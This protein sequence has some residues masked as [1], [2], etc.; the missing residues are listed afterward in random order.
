VSF[1]QSKTLMKSL[2]WIA[3]LYQLICAFP[4]LII[5]YNVLATAKV[6]LRLLVLFRIFKYKVVEYA[7]T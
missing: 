3:R 4:T 5:W 2:R 7:Y 1:L 6:K